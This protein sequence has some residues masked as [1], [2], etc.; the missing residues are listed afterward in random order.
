MGRERAA[1][2]HTVLRPTWFMANFTESFLLPAVTAQDLVVSPAGTDSEASI[3]AN[4]IA[5]V[6]VTTLVEHHQHDG[7]THTITGGS[8]LT[9]GQA[10]DLISDVTGR[11][12]SYLDIGRDQWLAASVAA[13][14]PQDYAAMLLGLF[15]LI[16]S[17]ASAAPTLT[18]SEILHRDPVSFVDFAAATETP[19]P[20]P[21][22][23]GDDAGQ[24]SWR[25][26]ARGLRTGDGPVPS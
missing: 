13:G 5:A 9:F 10:A 7:A 1:F 20:A 6:A 21:S 12:V 15:N 16:R 4:D 11:R 14:V 26:Q 17:E 19:G 18:T 22:T 3:S 23:H 2:S 25:A 24:P 8:A